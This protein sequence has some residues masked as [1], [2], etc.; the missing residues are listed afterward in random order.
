MLC[1]LQDKPGL[2]VAIKTCKNCTSDSVREK[3][4]QEACKATLWCAASVDLTYKQ[5][6]T[7]LTRDDECVDEC[8]FV[9]PRSDDASVRP[10][11]HRQA[12]RSDH[13]K[14]RVDHHGALYSRRGRDEAAGGLSV[15]LTSS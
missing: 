1:V 7:H 4:L 13:R 6:V 5:P 11:S 2:H 10:P 8:V 9:P 12:H 15:C 3:F 14:P